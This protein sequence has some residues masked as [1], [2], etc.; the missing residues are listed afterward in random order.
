VQ[1]VVRIEIVALRET[2]AVQALSGLLSIYQKII[3]MVIR[4]L[5][6]RIELRD[7]SSHSLGEYT[8]RH[9]YMIASLGG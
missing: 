9:L 4:R 1:A 3:E 7:S 2:R 5:K 8:G 6:A